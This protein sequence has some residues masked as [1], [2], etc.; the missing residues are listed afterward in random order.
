MSPF[1]VGAFDGGTP[2]ARV[3]VAV[4]GGTRP[5]AWVGTLVGAV[6]GAIVGAMVGTCL[7][8]LVGACVGGGIRVCPGRSSLSMVGRK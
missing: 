7:G 1:V 5:G 3:G 6:V 4:T 8:A 2:G